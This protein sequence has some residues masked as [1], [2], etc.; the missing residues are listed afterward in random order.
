MR[1][2][3]EALKHAFW[4][5][6]WTPAATPPRRAPRVREGWPALPVASVPRRRATDGQP[7]RPNGPRDDWKR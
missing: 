4:R 3:I 2:L 6:R 7:W 5:L 1:S